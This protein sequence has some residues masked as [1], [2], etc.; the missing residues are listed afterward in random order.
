MAS[1]EG[2][3]TLGP[4]TA[5]LLVHT[6]REGKA[7]RAGHD[8]EIEVEDWSATLH[9]GAAPADAQL[10]LTASSRSLHVLSGSGG[11]QTLGEDDKSS[12]KQTIDDEILKGGEILFRSTGAQAGPGSTAA[13]AGAGDHELQVDGDL[14]L[15]G[16]TR[17]LKLTLVVASDGTFSGAAT[18]RQRDF[19]IKP[20]SALFGTLKVKDEVTVTVDGRLPGP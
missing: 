13:K 15:V 11:I 12:I 18:L 6:G 4:A 8:L 7:A 10:S 20:Y 5:R 14:T 1:C 17:P 9:L 2:T 3:F 16:N 19:G